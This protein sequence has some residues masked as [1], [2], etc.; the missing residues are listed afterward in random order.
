MANPTRLPLIHELYQEYLVNQDANAL[1]SRVLTRYTVGTLR[2]LGNRRTP[3]QSSRRRA[4]LGAGC[5]L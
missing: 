5:R 4:G 2:A 3:A 1:A